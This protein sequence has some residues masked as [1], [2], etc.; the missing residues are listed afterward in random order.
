[1]S[2]SQTT[3]SVIFDLRFKVQWGMPYTA[4]WRSTRVVLSHSVENFNG[5][6]HPT[7]LLPFLDL[8]NIQARKFKAA[9]TSAQGCSLSLPFRKQP[10]PP[11]PL[12]PIS[13]Y[14]SQS[15]TDKS[16]WG[17]INPFS[18]THPQPCITI[19]FA[20]ADPS[21]PARV[22]TAPVA[23]C[24]HVFVHSVAGFRLG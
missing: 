15:Q 3:V 18:I 14:H 1:M 22:S 5:L 2:R 21:A 11:L 10:I 17:L 4:S 16:L 12:Q 8:E 19:M 13:R 9:A 20:A 7:L 24:L 23:F 6:D